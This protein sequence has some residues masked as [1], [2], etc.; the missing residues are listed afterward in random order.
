MAGDATAFSDK[1]VFKQD[2][3]DVLARLEGSPV[4]GSELDGAI[5][6]MASVPANSTVRYYAKSDDGEEVYPTVHY[7]NVY[8]L[9]GPPEAVRS[10]FHRILPHIDLSGAKH[11]YEE[12]ITLFTEERCI[13][14]HLELLAQEF[15]SVQI[16]SY[17]DSFS[18]RISVVL[19]SLDYTTLQSSVVR[20]RSI[21]NGVQDQLRA[22]CLQHWADIE[23]LISLG[24]PFAQKLKKAVSVIESFLEQ[25]SLNELSLS[26]NGGKDCT[27]LIHLLSA[28]LEK[29]RRRFRI[30]REYRINTLYVMPDDPF[31]EVEEFVDE[32]STRFFSNVTS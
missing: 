14:T 26:F 7:S 20:L 25:Y 23:A 17:P 1:L 16:G 10:I 15:P 24:G 22:R 28:V 21:T 29:N 27:I 12:T 13:Y 30:P 4:A 6:K 3:Y 18:S 19:S 8:I 32:C 2:L 11:I 31:D 9:P 5:K